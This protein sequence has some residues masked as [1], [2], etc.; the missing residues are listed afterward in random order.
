MVI[1][2]GRNERDTPPQAGTSEGYMEALA[3]CDGLE[4]CHGLKRFEH[5]PRRRPVNTS[6]TICPQHRKARILAQMQEDDVR[7]TRR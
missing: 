4:S 2:T 3:D 5:L 6:A 1:L 7:R